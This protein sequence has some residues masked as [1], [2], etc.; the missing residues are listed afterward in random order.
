[1]E[2]P[3]RAPWCEVDGHD[4][5]VVD[6][7]ESVTGYECDRRQPCLEVGAAYALKLDIDLTRDHL[8][9]KS[10]MAILPVSST[11]G[12][13]LTV[14]QDDRCLDRKAKVCG[15]LTAFKLPTFQ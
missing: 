14:A 3:V 9:H 2:A 5:C 1:M 7:V 15:D 12:V 6:G 10:S 4:R 13:A 8:V 11:S